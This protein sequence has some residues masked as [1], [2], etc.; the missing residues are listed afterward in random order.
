MIQY[1][2]NFMIATFLHLHEANQYIMKE[3]NELIILFKKF[4]K[5]KLK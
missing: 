2:K 5:Y 4:N 3:F 1:S